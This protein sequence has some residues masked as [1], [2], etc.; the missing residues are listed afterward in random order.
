[1]ASFTSLFL[2]DSA[3]WPT[4]DYPSL[5][6]LAQWFKADEQEIIY[7]Y[8]HGGVSFISRLLAGA[9]LIHFGYPRFG[10]ISRIG[11]PARRSNFANM[12]TS[13]KLA[14]RLPNT[15]MDFYNDLSMLSPLKQFIR[16]S[17]LTSLPSE[18][19]LS[20]PF[21]TD[22]WISHQMS[23]FM[24]KHEL[25]LPTWTLFNP[26]SE[27][28]TVSCCISHFCIDH[29]CPLWH[30]PPYRMILRVYDGTRHQTIWKTSLFQ[31]KMPK[32]N[33]YGPTFVNSSV[34]CIVQAKSTKQEFRRSPQ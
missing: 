33:V 7:I 14:K 34:W 32:E 27:M 10:A 5:S 8:A 9:I 12:L 22:I 4:T 23:W 18:V 6:K 20:V 31:I 25:Y 19:D 29:T 3:V 2:W 24:N 17:D 28:L 11:G 30:S 13:S 21:T 26:R 1:M 15:N 16:C